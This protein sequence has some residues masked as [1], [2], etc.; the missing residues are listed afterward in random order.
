MSIARR[1][2]EDVDA[3]S[4]LRCRIGCIKNFI[5]QVSSRIIGP[6]ACVG[7]G[8]DIR[9]RTSTTRARTPFAGHPNRW[10]MRY[11][12][13]WL[14]RAGFAGLTRC[15][16]TLAALPTNAALTTTS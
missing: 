13:P 15:N 7:V 5:D 12:L 14:Y 8:T 10:N 9:A 4:L 2:V 1:S 6:A 16:Q 3:V 11:L